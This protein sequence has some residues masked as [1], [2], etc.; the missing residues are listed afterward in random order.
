M[1]FGGVL[2]KIKL[3]TENLFR[4]FL[5]CSGYFMAFPINWQSLPNIL[6]PVEKRCR[7][8]ELDHDDACLDL[9]RRTH[10]TLL[11]HSWKKKLRSQKDLPETRVKHDCRTRQAELSLFRQSLVQTLFANRWGE[12]HQQRIRNAVMD[13]FEDED[14]LSPDEREDWLESIE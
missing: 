6:G 14:S 2:Q 10:F 12:K 7:W 4:E 5:V 3:V 9:G 11:P 1:H 8:G 13:L